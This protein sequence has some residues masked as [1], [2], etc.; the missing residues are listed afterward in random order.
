MLI[1]CRKLITS[2][3]LNKKGS[4]LGRINELI[5]DISDGRILFVIISFG[6]IYG[7]RGRLT[8]VP[9]R[10]FRFNDIQRKYVLN[11]ESNELYTAPGFDNNTWPETNGPY[12]SETINEYY[13]DKN[14]PIV[15]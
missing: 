14:D 7:F 3:I 2:T 13:K 6:G 4:K 8:A 10:L 11:V 5:L 9:W 15:Q 12:W 1:E